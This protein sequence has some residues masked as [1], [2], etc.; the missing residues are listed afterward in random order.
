MKTR[1]THIF[2]KWIEP[3]RHNR[4][5]SYINLI[6]VTEREERKHETEK[7]TWRHKGQNFPQIWLRYTSTDLRYSTN[8]R[9]YIHETDHAKTQLQSWKSNSKGKC[10]MQQEKNDSLHTGQQFNMWL[11]TQNNRTQKECKIKIKCWKKD[12]AKRFRRFPSKKIPLKNEGEIKTFLNKRKLREAIVGT[13]IPQQRK[14]FRL[15]ENDSRRRPWCLRKEQKEYQKYLE[16]YKM[17]GFFVV[18]WGFFLGGGALFFLHGYL[19]K[20]PWNSRCGSA[21]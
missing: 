2:I 18:L 10:W 19:K 3:Q 16:K 8:T 4:R 9:Q 20:K 17:L 14:L 12:H 13:P 21:G 15:K 6:G 7:N 1:N 11:L 5:Q